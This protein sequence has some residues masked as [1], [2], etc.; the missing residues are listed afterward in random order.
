[1]TTLQNRVSQLTGDGMTKI[2][3]AA[4]LALREAGVPESEI[5]ARASV[6]VAEMDNLAN[7]VSRPANPD[8]KLHEKLGK[9]SIV[10]DVVTINFKGNR[11]VTMTKSEWAAMVA[12]HDEPRQAASKRLA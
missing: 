5:P 12:K 3:D 8:F 2:G 10:G 11:T 4:Y 7:N 1:M 9:G 6:L